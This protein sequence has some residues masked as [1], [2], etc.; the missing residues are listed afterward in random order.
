MYFYK[1]ARFDRF[2]PSKF[3]MKTVNL[4]LNQ[5]TKNVFWNNIPADM[6]PFVSN[7]NKLGTWNVLYV[8][9]R[10]FSSSN[11]QQQQL[12][13]KNC[14]KIFLSIYLYYI[15]FLFLFSRNA[16]HSIMKSFWE[17]VPDLDCRGPTTTLFF[18]YSIASKHFFSLMRMNGSPSTIYEVHTSRLLSYFNC[19]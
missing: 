14:L 9:D 2:D 16:H 17:L 7:S 1:L 19:I 11:N 12:R 3:H 5:W 8:S 13:K 6:Q 18:V 10:F 4:T 15:Y